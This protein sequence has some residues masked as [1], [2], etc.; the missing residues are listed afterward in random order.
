MGEERRDNGV[1]DPFKLLLEESLG[2][3]RNAMMDNFV[4]ILRL[5][6][7][8][9][10]SCSSRGGAPFKVEINFDIPR[11]ESQIDADVVDK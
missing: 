6:P 1:G 2:Q 10:A 3:P 5:L 7:T 4:Q 11:F 9:E 8:G